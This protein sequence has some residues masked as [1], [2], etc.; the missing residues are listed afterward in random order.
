[1]RIASI[2]IGLAA[3]L[4]PAGMALGKPA[5]VPSTLNLRAAPGTGTEIVGKIPGGSLVDVGDCADN[6]CAVTWQDKKGFSIQ[7]GLDLS[8]RVPPR[9][10]VVRRYSRG[11]WVPAEGPVFY[12]PPPVYV[13]PPPYYYPYRYRRYWDRPYRGPHYH[14]RWGFGW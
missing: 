11:G 12:E 7:S 2:V 3:V 13:A 4:L 10:K 6:W 5:Y 14:F 8:G 9:R 1:M